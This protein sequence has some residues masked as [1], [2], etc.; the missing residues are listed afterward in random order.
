MTH[1]SVQYNGRASG[2]WCPYATGADLDSDQQVDDGHSLVFDSLPLAAGLEILGAPAVELEL[3]VDRP[4]AFIVARLCDVD[5][6][7][8]SARVT[9][10]VLNLTHRDSHEEPD[11]ARARPALPRAAAAQRHRLRLSGRTSRAAGAVDQLLADRLAVA[12][13]GHA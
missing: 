8:A 5:A 11:A 12:G 7:G 10:G 13:A 9:Y 6:R 1:C 4:L 2:A 3:A